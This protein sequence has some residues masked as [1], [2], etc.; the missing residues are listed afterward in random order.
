MYFQYQKL[1]KK[2]Q[3]VK[4]PCKK[5]QAYIVKKITGLARLHELI[6]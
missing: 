2:Q 1:P 6:R 5:R 4:S 3:P